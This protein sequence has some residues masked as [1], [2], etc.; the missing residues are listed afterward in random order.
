MSVWQG[1]AELTDLAGWHWNTQVQ[2]NT[3]AWP[4]PE[5]T[6]QQQVSLRR[7]GAAGSVWHIDMLTQ[8]WRSMKSQRITKVTTVRSEGNIKI[9]T[10]KPPNLII[11]ILI[12]FIYETLF[13]EK[14]YNQTRETQWIRLRNTSK[15]EVKT[16][17]RRLGWMDESECVTCLHNSG[18][19]ELSVNTRPN[20]LTAS[21][22]W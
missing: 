14:K 5:T 11:I 21:T 9:W 17:E 8:W 4:I 10:T 1:A 3:E 13:K 18:F 19:C 16:M 15:K 7:P 12:N 2:V 6:P 22:T 20:P